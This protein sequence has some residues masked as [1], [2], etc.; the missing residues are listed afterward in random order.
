[1]RFLRSLMHF[2][3]PRRLAERSPWNSLWQEKNRADNLLVWRASLPVAALGYAIHI[4]IDQVH[5]KPNIEMWITFRIFMTVFC[6]ACC[7]LLFWPAFYKSRFYKLPILA[8]VFV[9]CYMQAITVLWY[10]V[11]PYSLAFNF[12]FIATMLVRGTILESI[13]LALVFFAFQWSPL[14]AAGILPARLFSEGTFTLCCI[15][16]ARSSFINEIQSF[17][18][19]QKRIEAQKEI[20]R[21]NED[22]TSQIKGFLPRE[23]A[24]RLTEKMQDQKMTAL[25][26]M[27]EVLKPQKRPVACLYSD[28]RGFTDQSKD[29]DGFVTTSLLPNLEAVTEAI[30]ENHGIPRK[31]GDLLFSYFDF[32]NEEQNLVHAVRSAI[33]LVQLNVAHNLEH[34]QQ[35]IKRHTL[36]SSGPAVVGNL[37]SIH[38]SIEITAIGTPVNILSRIDELTKLEALKVQLTEIDIIITSDAANHLMRIYPELDLRKI[39]LENLNLKL[40]NFPDQ[41][42]IFLLPAHEAN[43]N[44]ILKNQSPALNADSFKNKAA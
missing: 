1:M 37:S 30:E 9:A 6:L 10:S 14:V 21:L 5:Q 4:Y 17:I 29:L 15:V 2:L 44:L 38:S 19:G 3:F 16:F 43:Q 41:T 26:A 8:F 33:R 25:Q 35:R 27:Q 36:M 31:I 22:F 13:G 24:S 23:I 40:R 7:A 39:C 12:V 28:V 11:I 42:E 20:L 32:Q 18:L 34:P